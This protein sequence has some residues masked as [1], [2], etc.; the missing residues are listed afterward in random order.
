MLLTIVNPLLIGGYV[1]IACTCEVFKFHMMFLFTVIE[2]LQV[3]YYNSIY[4]AHIFDIDKSNLIEKNRM[5]KG[6]FTIKIVVDIA[7]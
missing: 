5:L 3:Y 4:I 7:L 6:Y 1:D 2:N